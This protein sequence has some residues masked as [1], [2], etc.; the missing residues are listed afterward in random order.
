MNFCVKLPGFS[1]G[2]LPFRLEQNNS[3]MNTLVLGLTRF[4]LCFCSGLLFWVSSLLSQLT[5]ELHNPSVYFILWITFSPHINHKRPYCPS[6]ICNAWL[7][8]SI[9]IFIYPVRIWMLTD[10]AVS[11]YVK[12]DIQVILNHNHTVLRVTNRTAIQYSIREQH[13]SFLWMI[14]GCTGLQ[15]FEIPLNQRSFWWFWVDFFLVSTHCHN[16]ISVYR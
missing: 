4:N 5:N 1:Q 11:A 6:M 13:I 7:T 14:C 10:S 2:L 16:V 8:P 12:L 3:W 15:M 9:L